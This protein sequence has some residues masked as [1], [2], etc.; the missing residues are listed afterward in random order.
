MNRTSNPAPPPQEQ[1]PQQQ[2]SQDEYGGE[3]S[4]TGRPPVRLY[5]ESLDDDLFSPYHILIRRH[6]E[7]FEATV[8]DGAQRPLLRSS[9]TPT[10]RLSSSRSRHRSSGSTSCRP[11][12]GQVGVRC[13][14]CAGQPKDMGSLGSTHYPTNYSGVAPAVQIIANSHWIDHCYLVPT[15]VRMD[16]MNLRSTQ[17][18]GTIKT[19]WIEGLQ[20]LD[21]VE[22]E[23]GLLKFRPLPPQQQQ[24][25]RQQQQQQQQPQ[26]QQQ[27]PLQQQQQPQQQPQRTQQ[28]FV[29]VPAE[30]N[31]APTNVTMTHR[32]EE[33]Y[34]PTPTR[35]SPS[36]L[37]EFLVRGGTLVDTSSDDD[38][39]EG[40]VGKQPNPD[41]K[42]TPQ[43]GMELEAEP[44][45]DVTLLPPPQPQHQDDQ[46]GD[47]E[48]SLDV[49]KTGDNVKDS[50]QQSANQPQEENAT[51]P[52]PQAAKAPA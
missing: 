12:L 10:R 19:A 29:G 31:T 14:F 48:A 44:S 24:Q 40:K 42:K 4:L 45:K 36:S 35:P 25:P 6:V 28:V 5:L 9:C 11:V 13:C 26:Q 16:L 8:E 49:I 1:E 22:E 32:E 7:M 38:D 47:V 50:Q 51:G 37:L 18:T 33:R 52:S 17:N 46:K 39:K 21:I 23:P 34:H 43:W 20:A 15:S 41:V 27:Q 30:A 2:R 3:S